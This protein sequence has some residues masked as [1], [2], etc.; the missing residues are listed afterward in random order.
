MTFLT[1]LAGLVALA[2]LLVA[3]AAVLGRARAAAAGRALGLPPPRRTAGLLRPALAAGAIGLF[4]LAAAQP[5]L[6]HTSPH[7]VRMG[8]QALFVVDTSRSMAASAS[9]T[10]P[11]RLDRA[12]AAAE[13]LRAAIPDVAAGIA[14]LTDRA[15]PDLLPVPDAAA[16]DAVLGRAVAIESPPPRQTSVRA[17]TYGAL[18]NIASGD[19]FAPAVTRKI[20]VLL[21][22]GESN[23]VDP[24]GIAHALSEKRGYRLLAVRFWHSDEA[25]YD[26]GRP[27]NAYRPDPTGRALLTA[28]AEAAGGRAFEEGRLG[29]ASRYLVGV[30]GHG[31]TRTALGT[32]QT[33]TSLA[34]YVAIAALLL[35]AASLWR[36]IGLGQDVSGRAFRPGR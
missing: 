2:A 26:S 9:P 4:G 19:Y 17:T 11:T 30:A 8:V 33:R 3:A 25:V 23:P 6:T 24:G 12:R 27:E 5:A 1:P 18:A 29:A 22:D 15:L 21:T 7:R 10:S 16:F 34:P 20:V 36:R 31:P 35:L 28:V 32:E 13:R 14:T